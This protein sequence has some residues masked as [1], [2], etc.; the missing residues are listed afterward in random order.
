MLLASAQ[1]IGRIGTHALWYDEVLSLQ[2]SGGA[3]F[4]AASLGEVLARVADDRGWPPLYNVTLAVWGQLAGWST[5]AARYLSLL[6]GVL[7]LA[8]MARLAHLL[9]MGKWG[10][11]AAVSVLA[12]SAFYTYYLAEMRGYTLYMLVVLWQACAYWQ[13]RQAP[14]LTFA[15][16]ATLALSTGVVL[17]TH[18]IASVSL[19]GIGAHLLLTT[20]TRRGV[21]L[22]GALAAGTLLFSPWAIYALQAIATE[23]AMQRGLDVI[24]LAQGIAQAFSNGV[25]LLFLAA[26]TLGALVAP[27]RAFLGLWAACMLVTALLFNSLTSFLFHVRHIIALLVPFALWLVAGGQK[28]RGVP[29][30]LWIV[31]GV[32][33]QRS[34]T[35]M[36]SLPR[37]VTP[38]PAAYF[39]AVVAIAA[40]T[41]PEDALIFH[42]APTDTSWTHDVVLGYY[43]HPLPNPYAQLDA[44]LDLR[45]INALAMGFYYG[46]DYAGRVRAVTGDAPAVWLFINPAVPLFE[47]FDTF[48][49]VLAN[50]P[51]LIYDKPYLR[52]L[53]YANDEVHFSCYDKEN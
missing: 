41:A 9:G 36:A 31:A 11:V 48:A 53:R 47:K 49:E 13:A 46:E 26:A 52:V 45:Y 51:Q 12:F 43:L 27:R 39:E 30:L 37:H 40:C 25:P 8:M 32:V 19:V 2:M 33:A 28:L 10:S 21:W 22:L 1:S 42:T 23:R 4:T 5:F 44:M 7:S 18:Y 6:V 38:L 3:H 35:F 20:R 15:A 34:D 50:P 17:L 24:T 29:L 16:W 14:R